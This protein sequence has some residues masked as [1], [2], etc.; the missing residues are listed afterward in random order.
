LIA[1]VFAVILT[2]C[3]LG[4]GGGS[5]GVAPASVGSYSPPP[6][7]LTDRPRVGITVFKVEG[8][9]SLSL[10][11]SMSGQGLGE[12]TADQMAELLTK[13]GRFTVIAREEFSSLLDRQQLAG[14]VRPGS[15]VRPA[16]IDGIDYVLVG[17]VSSLSVVK[18]SEDPGMMQRFTDFVSQSAS[19]KQVIV[20]ATCGI[21]FNLID[22]ETG[23]I[24]ISNNSE[25][26]RTAG[27]KDLGIDVMPGAA[28]ATSESAGL[29]VSRQDRVQ[30]IRLA[31]DDAIRKSLPKVDR[32]LESRQSARSPGGRGVAG[33]L[34][35]A[36]PRASSTPDRTPVVTEQPATAPTTPPAPAAGK[37]ACP[38]CETENDPNVRFCRKC[39]AKVR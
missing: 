14:V 37:L 38:V 30:I 19:N 3:G 1:P 12:T 8:D 23:D 5:G 15:L 22:P 29:S 20:T 28:D 11:Q 7:S 2:G 33:S 32:F 36:P 17:T 35:N 25:L 18:K 39:G 24:V 21:G 31:L 26:N 4:S 6:A 9:P 10:P 27:A 13:T 34:G 16:D